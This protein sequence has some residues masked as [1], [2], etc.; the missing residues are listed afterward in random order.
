MQMGIGFNFVTG[1][2]S[3]KL[4]ELWATSGI[5]IRD[6]KKQEFSGF[7]V[8]GGVMA[9]MTE[10]LNL[11][12]VFRTPYRKN[13][14]GES[15]LVY[16]APTGGTD[17]TIAAS[18]TSRYD[19]PFV[20]G[21]GVSYVIFPR[22]IVGADVSFFNWASYR[23]N[24]FEEEMDRNFRNAIKGTVGA[25]FLVPVQLFRKEA[26]VPIRIGFGWDEQPM[27]EPRSGYAFFSAGTGFHWNFIAL[28]VGAS[29]GRENGSG[30][31]LEARRMALSM[32][33]KL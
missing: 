14:P 33:L 27:K 10:K 12:L 22:F 30:D 2:L 3:R 8:N 28:D 20:L 16:D 21:L 9:R 15:A 1:E 25:E 13:S 18:A 6:T 29:F 11:A 31:S 23:V 26:T 17:I 4:E 5:I 19:Q 7:F 32:T 24:Y